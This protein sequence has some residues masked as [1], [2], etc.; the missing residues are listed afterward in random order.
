MLLTPAQAASTAGPE[1]ALWLRKAESGF[2]RWGP[3][4]CWEAKAVNAIQ[5]VGLCP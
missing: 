5:A 2:P 1:G 3:A 4:L